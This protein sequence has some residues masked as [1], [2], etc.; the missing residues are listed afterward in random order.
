MHLCVTARLRSAPEQR[1]DIRANLAPE[2]TK[3]RVDA[4]RRNSELRVLAPDAQTRQARHGHSAGAASE[5]AHHACRSGGSSTH[6]AEHRPSRRQIGE[7]FVLVRFV[8]AVDTEECL[9]RFMVGNE[10]ARVVELAADL[11]RLD[12][13]GAVPRLEAVV[14]RAGRTC[15]GLLRRQGRRA[16]GRGAGLSELAL[17][18]RTGEGRRHRRGEAQGRAARQ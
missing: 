2:L 17:V 11:D 7:R 4:R 18:F 14:H 9:L 10:S 1:I 5:T 13:L 8:A 6:T 12:R 3:I 15:R 16:D